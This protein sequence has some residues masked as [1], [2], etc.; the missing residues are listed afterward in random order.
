MYL[1]R[2]MSGCRSPFDRPL[3]IGVAG[4]SRLCQPLFLLVLQERLQVTLHLAWYHCLLILASSC[5]WRREHLCMIHWKT[6]HKSH[7]GCGVIPGNRYRSL[8]LTSSICCLMWLIIIFMFYLLCT[9]HMK[10]RGIEDCVFRC[11]L[12]LLCLAPIYRQEHVMSLYM[13]LWSLGLN[14]LRSLLTESEMHN[15]WWFSWVSMGH[16]ICWGPQLCLLWPLISCVLDFN[17]A[18]LICWSLCSFQR[19]YNLS[20]IPHG[21]PI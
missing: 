2:I 19:T 14:F 11:Y 15:L 8:K 10:V 18:I 12:K 1:V 3:I 4:I 13:L 7:R 6:Y 17:I 21:R 16:I 9:H 20:W 5:A